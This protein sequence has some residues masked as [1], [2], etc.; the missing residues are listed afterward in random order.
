MSRR[1]AARQNQRI[2]LLAAAALVVAVSLVA[3]L[4]QRQPA[5]TEPPDGGAVSEGLRVYRIATGTFAI[6]PPDR[7]PFQY[8]AA[9]AA[10]RRDGSPLAVSLWVEQTEFETG[11]WRD[12]I[13]VGRIPIARPPQVDFPREVAVLVWPVR[14][15]APDSLLRANGLIA[16]SLNLQHVSLELRV[17]PDTGGPIPATP[18][19]PNGVVPYA[20]FTIPRSQWP[21]PA[22]PPTVPPLTVTLAR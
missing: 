20:L 18:I 6:P 3:S 10:A 7:A 4:G 15:V 1:A 5:A 22:P 14:G 11:G 12:Q 9:D 17:K 2:F 19:A 8:T 16:D 21:L 13:Q